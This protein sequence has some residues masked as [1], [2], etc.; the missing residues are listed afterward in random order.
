MA[1]GNPL[2][3]LVV[4]A[5]QIASGPLNRAANSGEAA[6]VLLVV[7][8]AGRGVR[9]LGERVQAG[10]VHALALPSHRDVEL[11]DAKVERLQRALEELSVVERDRAGAS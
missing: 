1:T 8:R 2:L 9:R 5:E 4:R 3:R 10:V 7:A 6:D 11:L